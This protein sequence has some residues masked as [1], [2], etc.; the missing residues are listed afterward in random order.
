MRHPREIDQALVDAYLARRALDYLVGFTLSP[1][2]WR[3]LPGRALGRPRA[4]GGAAPRLRPRARDRDVRRARILVDRRD[5][6]DRRT[7]APF[8]GAARRRR[9]QEDQR[10]RHRHGR[11]GAKPSSATLERRRFSVAAVEAKPAKRHPD[12]A[13]HHLDPAAGGLAQA[14]PRAGAHHADRAAALRGRRHRRRDGR[15]HHLYAHRRRRHGARGGRTAA[16]RVI[17]KEFGDRYVPGA[18]RNY[19]AKAKNA[20]EAHEAIRPTDM[21]RLPKRRRALSRARAGA[22]STS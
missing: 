7:A 16:R 20:Q 5:A 14:R 18:P 4:V 6:R 9:R 8:D 15:P 21:S 22:G 11:G 1:V 3:K 12:A 19:T 2:L 17:G 13:V 10:A